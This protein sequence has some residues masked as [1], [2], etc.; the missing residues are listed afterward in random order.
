VD[1]DTALG[2][3]SKAGFSA[4]TLAEILENKGGIQHGYFIESSRG[5]QFCIRA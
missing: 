5:T 2:R 1:K 4:V 3:M